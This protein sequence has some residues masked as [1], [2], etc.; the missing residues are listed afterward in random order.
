MV[1]GLDSEKFSKIPNETPLVL[2]R[3]WHEQTKGL[4]SQVFQ[5]I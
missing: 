5:V 2:E 4:K 3:Y 1:F